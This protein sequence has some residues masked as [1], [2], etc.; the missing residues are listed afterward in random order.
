MPGT[1]DSH[2]IGMTALVEIGM[3]VYSRTRRFGRDDFPIGGVVVETIGR[4]VIEDGEPTGEIRRV[5]EVLNPYE[6]DL[7]EAFDQ[8][9]EHDVNPE[10]VEPAYDPTLRL[11][12]CRLDEAVF[13]RK[14]KA[15]D[16]RHAKYQV[17]AG[18]LMSVI[19]GGLA[20]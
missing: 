4:P 14:G 7:G 6:K 20:A 13:K 8:I 3:T 10:T 2:H 5:Y 11:L 19:F 16:H 17:I 12:V 15:F 9:D 18:R 1:A